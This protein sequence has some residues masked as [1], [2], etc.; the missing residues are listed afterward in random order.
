MYVGPTIWIDSD[1]HR[2]TFRQSDNRLTDYQNS[3][4]ID[5]PAARTFY[6]RPMKPKWSVEQAIAIGT[7]FEKICVDSTNVTLGAPFAKYYDNAEFVGPA[8]AATVKKYHTGQWTVSWPRVDTNGH[9]FAG[10][11]VTIQMQE[12]YAPLGVGVYLTTPYAD[13]K[14]EPIS[15]SDALNKAEWTVF[16]RQLG[17]KIFYYCVLADEYQRNVTGDQIL[18]KQLIVVLPNRSFWGSYYA[19]PAKTKARLAWVIWFR[20]IHSSKSTSGLGL[21]DEDFAVW[22]DAHTGGV[23][24]G[25]AML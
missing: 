14:T 12:G 25:D 4:L 6:D 5:G 8:G 9:P 13:E 1:T 18:S 20:P 19:V 17:E 3:A 11:H 22:I 23:I 10:D 21:Y 7:A 15:E 2:F 24:G 16:W